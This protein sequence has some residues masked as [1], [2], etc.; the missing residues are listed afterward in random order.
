[1]IRSLPTENFDYIIGSTDIDTRPLPPFD[2]RVC[3]FL[4]ALSSHLMAD[5][6]AKAFPDVMTFA[7]WCRKGHIQKLKST[8]TTDLARLGRG[9]AL[10]I[11]P[12]NV[13]VNFAF[14]FAFGL[15]SGNANVVR[16]ASKETPQA[17][18]IC[19]AIGSVIEDPAFQDIKAMT[20][21][22][23]YPADNIIT[24]QF[25]EIS[26]A[27]IIWGGDQTIKSIRALRTPPRCVDLAFADRTSFCVMDV[28]SVEAADDQTLNRLAQDFYNDTYLMDQN[29][30]SS[31]HLVVWHGA[32]SATARQRFWEALTSLVE[33]AY[34][35][36]AVQAVDKYTATLQAAIDL[37]EADSIT[38]HGINVIRVNLSDLPQQLE[39]TRGQFGLFFE[40]TTSDLGPLAGAISPKF[41]TMTYFG[42]DKRALSS[43]VV[44]GRLRGID[45]IVPVGRALAIDVMWDGYDV[46]KHLSRVVA[47]E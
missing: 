43:F 28:K 17:K 37:N 6:A 18:I 12:S 38:R 34:S 30:C 10:H 42:I 31:P 46:V 1:M 8:F 25:S 44:D 22:V 7:F 16:I 27:R 14:S 40:H 13:P 45:R 35:L 4:N 26:D 20:A 33:T 23:S 39:S 9:L 5:T 47:V 11:A 21:M 41:Q 32:D 29:A 15:L 36:E 2:D 3:S 24:E 19:G